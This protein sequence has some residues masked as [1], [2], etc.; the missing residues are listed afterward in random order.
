MLTHYTSH[1]SSRSIP[2]YHTHTYLYPSLGFYELVPKDLV[3]LF[4]AGEL[5]LLSCGLPDIDIEDLRAHTDYYGYTVNDVVITRYDTYVLFFIHRTC[6]KYHT[7]Y[8]IHHTSNHY[9]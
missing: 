9:D 7:P 5:E 1:F 8:T 3:N 2:S 6:M 4:D